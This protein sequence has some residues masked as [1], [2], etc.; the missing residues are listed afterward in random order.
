MSKSLTSSHNKTKSKSRS[1]TSSILRGI[2]SMKSKRC[3]RGTRRLNGECV[4]IEDYLLQQSM[5]P[6]KNCP[7]GTRKSKVTGECIKHEEFLVEQSQRLRKNCPPGT[8]RNS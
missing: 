8:R 7:K 5:I 3:P 2:T 1:P 6:R 4:K